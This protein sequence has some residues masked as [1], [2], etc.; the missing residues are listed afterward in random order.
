M[1]WLSDVCRSYRWAKRAIL[2][3]FQILSTGN[4]SASLVLVVGNFPRSRSFVEESIF[5]ADMGRASIYLIWLAKVAISLAL[6]TAGAYGKYLVNNATN[7]ILTI[8]GI[9]YSVSNSTTDVYQMDP[10]IDAKACTRDAALMQRLGI[11]TIYVQSL[12]A[13]QNHDACFSVFNSIG[14]YIVLLLRPP[15]L[16]PK[17]PS[18]AY[19]TDLMKGTFEIIDAIKDY[20]NLLA[21]DIGE[22]QSIGVF[23]GD[24]YAEAMLL[25]RTFIRD[26][27]EYIA[28]NAARSILTGGS[29]VYDEGY[30]PLPNDLF[31]YFQCAIDGSTN[32][33]SRTDYIAWE[34]SIVLDDPASNTTVAAN[35]TW[36]ELTDAIQNS[37][38]PMWLSFYETFTFAASATDLVFE[39]SLNDTALLFNMTYDWN[40]LAPSG[41]LNGGVRY[42]WAN[43]GGNKEPASYLVMIDPNGNMQLTDNYDRL[44]DI[45]SNINTQAFLG[46]SSAAFYGFT[47]NFDPP[48]CEEKL[49]V[50]TTIDY[51]GTT[52]TLATQWSM[53]T[54][55]SGLDAVITS[56]A[57]GTRGQMV[58]VAITTVV[59]TIKD[60]SGKVLTD[61]SIQPSKSSARSTT[62]AATSTSTSTSKPDSGLSTG[63]KA[64]I[65]VG[66]AVGVLALVGAGLFWFLTN[67][68]KKNA[69]AKDGT[70]V[71]RVPGKEEVRERSELYSKPPRPGELEGDSE[72][73]R[74]PF[75]LLAVDAPQEL[76]GAG[77][78]RTGTGLA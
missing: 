25:Y 28:R 62:G 56:G 7:N 5:S 26:T 1:C 13:T 10:L 39:Q 8:N 3:C 68:S 75:E 55:P 31:D 50:N 19:S 44:Q 2:V 21:V 40:L 27:K 61:V 18:A 15:V 67:R 54:R 46:G 12:D 72:M 4:A 20:E 66:V 64:G 51:G 59:H 49:I 58:D 29:V 48:V 23:D 57:G 38:V 60:S 77:I 78:R 9:W 11:N 33:F 16:F 24:S 14:I 17:D 41:L 73:A 76:G 74:P 70:E 42:K 47:N 30:I 45:F 37:S 22:F 34:T 69:T 52:Y 32:D 43:V 71:P 35:R 36:A 63:A 53:P 6:D 65:G